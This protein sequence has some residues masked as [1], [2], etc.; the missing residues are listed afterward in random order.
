MAWLRA[1]NHPE[2]APAV[3]GGFDA[4]CE[5][6]CA[7]CAFG[8]RRPALEVLGRNPR[9]VALELAV[10]AATHRCEGRIDEA[11]LEHIVALL[12]DGRADRRY[13]FPRALEGADRAAVVRWIAA[14][15]GPDNRA[16]TGT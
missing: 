5:P 15:A 6:A 11:R 12:A 4:R 8:Y 10:L 7:L 1:F 9:I 14:G 13:A 3:S 2:A 16:E